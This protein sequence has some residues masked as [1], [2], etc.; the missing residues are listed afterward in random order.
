LS[1]LI[2]R[3]ISMDSATI[4]QAIELL[5]KANADLEPELLPV[6]VARRLLTSYARAGRLVDFGIA[7][8]ARKLDDA[9]ELSEGHRD[10]G[11]QGQGGRRYRQDDV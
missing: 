11:G 2:V 4:D 8:L 10:V 6:P 7:G 3:I 1:H 9:S 5:E